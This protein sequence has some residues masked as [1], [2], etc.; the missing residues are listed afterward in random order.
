M[1]I[2]LIDTHCH[3]DYI[4]RDGNSLCDVLSSARENGV[5]K[6]ITISTKTSMFNSDILPILNFGDDI[7]CSI[8][9]HP[10]SSALMDFDVEKV[11]DIV[12]NIHEIA[13]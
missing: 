1:M 12:D 5:K 4:N 13:D 10:D 9:T 3:L 8:G 2:N 7:F 6:M 11:V